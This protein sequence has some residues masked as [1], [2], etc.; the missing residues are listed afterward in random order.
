M[1]TDKLYW[2]DP[3][4]LAF[5]AERACRSTYGH[6][7]SIVLE[8]TLFYPEAGGQLADMGMLRVAGRELRVEDVQVDDAGDIHHIVPA[9]ESEEDVRGP[10]TGSIDAARR[11][12]HMAQHTAQHMLS[13]ALVDAA[14][15]ETVSA[16]LG[17]TLCTID[18]GR[19]DIPEAEVARAEDLVNDVIMNDVAVRA[20]FPSA[21]ELAAM[22]LRREPKVTSNI[23]VIDI[24]GFDL[25]PCGGTHCTRTGQIGSLRVAG[26]ERYKGMVRVSFHAGQRALADARAAQAVVGGLAREFTCGPLDVQ[27]A[28]AK[29]RADLKSRLDA[30]SAARGELVDLVARAALDAN[31]PGTSGTTMIVLSRDHDDLG[32]L[33]TL[34]G[35]L[36]ARDDVVAVCAAP[37]PSSGDLLVVVQ[38]GA[39]AA[40]DCGRWL[41]ESA[42]RHGG[43]GG[44]RPERAE[45]RLARGADLPALLRAPL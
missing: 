17:A 25:S 16:R 45:G 14:R 9:L 5:E 44:G 24:D 22:K 42:A 26:V 15:A 40:F 20:L 27:N 35:R 34:A 31:P 37:D 28:V 39:K 7:P 33:R 1:P 41:K 36:S 32:M 23:R 10:A 12:D 21:E 43:R 29:L 18:V 11:R 3:F 4:A 38:R 19:G 30:L 6:K 2:A 13:R 8:R